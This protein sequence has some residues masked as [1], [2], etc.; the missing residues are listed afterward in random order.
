M[1]ETL[2]SIIDNYHNL[3]IVKAGELLLRPVDA[4]KLADEL[5]KN[6]ILILGVDLW[7]YIGNKIAEDPGSLELSDISDVKDNARVAKEFIKNKLPERTEFVSFILE[8]DQ[9]FSSED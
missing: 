8:E 7:Y 3:G 4:V 6:G 5:E 1:I 9:T 2:R